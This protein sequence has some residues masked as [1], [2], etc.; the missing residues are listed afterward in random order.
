MVGHRIPAYYYGDD[1][2]VALSKEEAEQKAREKFG[3]AFDTNL[4]LVQDEDVLIL[5]FRAGFYQ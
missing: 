5:G 4:L 2:F 1:V 3:E